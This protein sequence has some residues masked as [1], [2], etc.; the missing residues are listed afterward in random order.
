METTL[1]KIL[2]A[3][4]AIDIFALGAM[5]LFLINARINLKRQIIQ[6]RFYYKT[7]ALSQTADSAEEAASKLH[8][9]REEFITYC[10][11]KN[12][13]LPGKRKER[14]EKDKKTKDEEQKR[15][16]EEEAAW[17][18]DQERILEERRIAQE[19][20]SQKRKEHL[21]KFGFR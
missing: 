13:E 2:M 17:R 8:I 18:S 9:N 5:I 6:K 15:I 10:E 16:M 19:E 12:I 1:Y 14:L 20:E 11:E 21:K 7:L 4:V 3:I